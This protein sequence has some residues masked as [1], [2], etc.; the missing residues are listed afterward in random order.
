M[1]SNKKQAKKKRVSAFFMQ[2]RFVALRIEPGTPE[3]PFPQTML[4]KKR[5]SSE[6]RF[7]II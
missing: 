1:L 7:D 6:I 4:Y 5:F 2:K 3:Q